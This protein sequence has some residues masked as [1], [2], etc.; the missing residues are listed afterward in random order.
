MYIILGSTSVSRNLLLKEMGVTFTA[1]KPDIDEKTIRFDDPEQLTRALAHAKADALV[2]CI[3]EPTLLITSDQV[4][5]YNGIIRE[6][7]VD[8]IEARYFLE[9]APVYPAETVSAVVV[10]NTLTGKRYEG[11]GRVKIFFKPFTK[12][13]I[14]ILIKTKESLRCAG[15]F[16]A[17]HPLV[18]PFI[19]RM[20]GDIDSVMGLPK[21]L[22]RTLLEQAQK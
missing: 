4:V 8:E 15:G 22:T 12:E 14:D 7:P 17:E 2:P 18:T 13:V 20:E 10:T 16:P 3:Q 6:K 19:I 9:S 1:M 11:V 5:L 21:K